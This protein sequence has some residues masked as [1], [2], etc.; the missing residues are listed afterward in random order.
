M[1]KYKLKEGFFRLVIIPLSICITVLVVSCGSYLGVGGETRAISLAN[2]TNP[3]DTPETPKTITPN[4]GKP[5]EPLENPII[6]PETNHNDPKKPKIELADADD[7]KDGDSGN[8]DDGS[9]NEDVEISP[10]Q[11]SDLT[12][13]V[14]PIDDENQD[15]PGVTTPVE[16]ENGEN[17]PS[18]EV[19]CEPKIIQAPP[20][21]TKLTITSTPDENSIE[22]WVRTIFIPIILWVMAKVITYNVNRYHLIKTLYVDISQQILIQFQWLARIELWVLNKT[23]KPIP[24]EYSTDSHKMFNIQS[25]TLNVYIDALGDIK[26]YLW[27]KEIERVHEFY[28]KI[29]TIQNTMERALSF[30]K[31]NKFLSVPPNIFDTIPSH[32]TIKKNEQ[33]ILFNIEAA[34]RESK[35][36]LVDLLDLNL[37]AN[38]VENSLINIVKKLSNSNEVDHLSA[39]IT[40]IFFSRRWW[41][42]RFLCLPIFIF[43]SAL[44]FFIPFGWLVLTSGYILLLCLSIWIIIKS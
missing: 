26:K 11:S 35:E 23:D 40:S 14:D 37:S 13:K 9:G 2:V 18:C 20:V 30:Q 39:L 36:I 21:T 24:P 5:D 17:E 34:Y 16:E 3:P 43:I 7:N 6:A 31:E 42:P 33:E 12:P 22:D 32:L 41:Y 15:E 10:E 28:E 19:N 27:C 25:N 1:R 38:K 8:G 29:S 44:L 4:P